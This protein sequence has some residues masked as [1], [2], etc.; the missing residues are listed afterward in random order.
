MAIKRRYW[1]ALSLLVLGS[2]AGCSTGGF[3]LWPS[4]SSWFG[5]G[6]TK[7]SLSQQ[8]RNT[9]PAVPSKTGANAQL[10]AAAAAAPTGIWATMAA[11][12]KS[13]TGSAEPAP[14]PQQDELSLDTAPKQLSP[15]LLVQMARM[16]EA[17]GDFPTAIKHYEDALKAA[18]RNTDLLVGLARAYDRS[19]NPA[20]S[21]ETY[22]Q[23]INVDPK[24]AL[25]HND[26]GLCYARHRDLARSHES[27][28]QAVALVPTSKLYRNNLATVFVESRQYN[29]AYEQLAAVHPPAIAHYNLGILANRR[30]DKAEAV[31]RFQQAAT[32]DPN[33]AQAHRMIEKIN[34][35]ASQVAQQPAQQAV[36][37]Q[38]QQFQ[39]QWRNQAQQQADQVKTQV[40]QSRT[41]FVNQVQSQVR[42]VQS[43]ADQGVARAGQGA[44]AAVRDAEAKIRAALQA[45]PAP[46]G[47]T[48]GSNWVPEQSD[49]ITPIAATPEANEASPAADASEAFSISDEDETPILLPPTGE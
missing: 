41:Q 42:D 35:V 23:A 32:I 49:D 3:N 29:E 20:K 38:I 14:V 8:A 13:L 24:C 26:L 18:P 19:G 22:R 5:T 27:L 28:S 46:V 16:H 11:P 4:G 15:E 37:P 34:G 45:Q 10:G 44:S 39:N 12:F 17:K 21:I 47:P 6:D 25:A 9:P 1:I 2:S 31:A 33:L 48:Y 36:Q 43:Q 40:Q 30:G 7:P